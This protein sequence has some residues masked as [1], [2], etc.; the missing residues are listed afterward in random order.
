MDNIDA[1]HNFTI[2]AGV[3]AG[4]VGPNAFAYG[5]G[6]LPSG[7]ANGIGGQGQ[8]AE[9]NSSLLD[10]WYTWIGGDLSLT[11]EVQG[12]YT[13]ALTR[14]AAD[15]SGGLS[16]IIPKGTGNFAAALEFGLVF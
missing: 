14:F 4:V 8:L 13:P 11:D 9:V 16:D 12:R 15:I 5:S 10:G 1:N 7:G 3:P 6:G 2:V